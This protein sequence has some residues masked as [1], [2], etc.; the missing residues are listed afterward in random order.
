M[1]LTLRFYTLKFANFGPLIN[2][3]TMRILRN[4]VFVLMTLLLLAVPANAQK[5]FEGNIKY[6]IELSGE[7]ADETAAFMPEYYV[8]VVK[9]QKL[10]FKME[11]GMMA[12]MMGEII[13]DGEHIKSWMVKHSEKVAYILPIE[14]DKEEP[15]APE[16]YKEDEVINIVGL[17]CQKYK[18]ISDA[19]DGAKTT[20]Y[21]WVTDKYQFDE[22]GKNGKL[23]TGGIFQ[24]DIKG[25]PLKIM[26]ETNGITMIMTATE[27]DKTKVPDSEFEV[28]ENYEISE[29]DASQSGGWD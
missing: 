24:K 10:K 13:V 22:Y 27:F 14:G 12:D 23:N 29:F 3:R 26:S 16:I 6:S 25:I 8:F 18:V 2:D 15:V 11:G 28:P 1:L 9:G 7:G 19:G 21:L 4:T 5:A 20:Q 17:K